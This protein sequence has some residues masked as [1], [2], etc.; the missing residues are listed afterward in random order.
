[1]LSGSSGALGLLGSPSLPVPPQLLWG[2]GLGV[3]QHTKRPA[4][5]LGPEP[6]SLLLGVN[7]PAFRV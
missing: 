1:M 7:V 6:H 4:E 3:P 2:V 5:G